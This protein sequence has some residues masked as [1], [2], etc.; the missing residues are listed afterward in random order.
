MSGECMKTEYFR[1]IIIL[2]LTTSLIGCQKQSADEGQA[3]KDFLNGATEESISDD[4]EETSGY[5]DYNFQSDKEP[6]YINIQDIVTI[7]FLHERYPGKQIINYM[8]ADPQVWYGR[9]ENRYSDEQIVAFNDYL[10]ENNQ[11]YVL[12]FM[13]VPLEEMTLQY[14]KDKMQSDNPPDIITSVNQIHVVDNST[15]KMVFNGV[16]EKL[17]EYSGTDA[18]KRLMNAYPSKLYDLSL[19]NGEF[20]GFKTNVFASEVSYYQYDS[21]IANKYGIKPEDVEGKKLNEIIGVLDKVKGWD[22]EYDKSITA[23]YM[24]MDIYNFLPVSFYFDNYE[25]TPVYCLDCIGIDA[26][27]DS[28]DIISITD[29][30]ALKEE[31]RAKYDMYQKGYSIVKNRG[32]SEYYA[33]YSGNDTDDFESFM[34]TIALSTSDTEVA[35]AYCSWK[36]ND[37]MI[38][39]PGMR[40][41]T[42]DKLKES[43]I[44]GI[45][46]TSK[47]KEKALEAM[48]FICGDKVLSNIL[49]DGVGR[50]GYKLKNYVPQSTNIYNTTGAGALANQYIVD[51]SYD[52]NRE[53][54]RK[55]MENV[56]I[57]KEIEGY[58]F[59]LT[60]YKSEMEKI[61]EIQDDML[62]NYVKQAELYS[63]KYDSFDEAWEDL[64]RQLREAGIDE[65]LEEIN[66]QKSEIYA[67]GTD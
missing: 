1:K 46:S 38:L 36:N 40:T 20:Y 61:R 8:Y 41:Y 37:N 53:M 18:Y 63:D 14:V 52:I 47:N 28:D 66:R 22:E 31:Y 9:K 34:C 30:K 32:E 25:R 24:T 3:A 44:N 42:T 49:V 23:S 51:N 48:A 62:W 45:C 5:V 17:D 26:N 60:K 65:V 50:S 11:D 33:I 6:V 15:E 7:D 10:V 19:Y 21:N 2:L 35:E 56:I 39:V 13:P 12:Y 57:A 43:V 59:D 58:Y 55:S 4:K 27:S 16:Y 29:S 64:D 54:A 67:G